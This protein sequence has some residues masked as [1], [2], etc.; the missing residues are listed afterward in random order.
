MPA[1]FDPVFGYRLRWTFDPRWR[2]GE[3]DSK[4]EPK[5]ERDSSDPESNK[6]EDN[7]RKIE[8]VRQKL[9]KPF[10]CVTEPF[11]KTLELLDDDWEWDV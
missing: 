1:N 2:I 11:K 5:D 8:Q 9:N 4:P 3:G 7:S 10:K 6:R